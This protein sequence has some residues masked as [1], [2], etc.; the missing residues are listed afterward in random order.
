MFVPILAYHKVQN[1]AE[2]SVTFVSPKVFEA[3]ISFLCKAGF[4]TVSIHDYLTG[5]DIPDRPVI[6]TFDDAYSSVYENA[7]PILQRYNFTATI[8]VITRFIGNVNQWDYS[9]QRTSHCDHA[10]LQILNEAGWEIGSHTVN[11]LNLK[12]LSDNQLWYELRYSKDFLENKL[13]KAIHIISYPFGKFDGRVISL[14]KQAGYLGGCTLGYNYPYDQ[15]FP[16]ALFRRGVYFFEP[17]VLFRAKLENSVLSHI[18]DLK[19]KFITFCSQGT[20]FLQYLRS[21]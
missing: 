5:R 8:F 9:F 13:K 12:T 4:K 6:I 2:L 1:D 10:Q 11:H 19:Q 3:Q 14:V 20:L 7:F 18:D 21:L 15:V 16:Y 17:S